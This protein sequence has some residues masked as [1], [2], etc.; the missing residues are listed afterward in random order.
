MSTEG[1]GV[2]TVIFFFKDL[3]KSKRHVA[4]NLYL[5]QIKVSRVRVFDLKKNEIILIRVY[6]FNLSGQGLIFLF[7]KKI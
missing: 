1:S 7:T 5:N 4:Y 6:L 3:K 2:N